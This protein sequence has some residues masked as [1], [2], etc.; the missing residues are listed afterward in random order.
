[1]IRSGYGVKS[2]ET[3]LAFLQRKLIVKIDDSC[4]MANSLNKC[5]FIV[6]DGNEIVKYHE[7]GRIE[8]NNHKNYNAR[9]KRYISEFCPV[10]LKQKEW[11]WFIGD[12]IF[13]S[14]MI[15]ETNSGWR[16]V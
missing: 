14:H 7:D 1:M 15:F 11:Q 2:Y 6:L 9:T 13:F 4:I 3:A 16:K 5:I 8:V 10:K 12:Q